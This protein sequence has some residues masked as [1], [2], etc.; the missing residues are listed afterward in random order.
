MPIRSMAD[1]DYIYQPWSEAKRRARSVDARR[2]LG[3]PDGMRR[4]YGVDVPDDIAPRVQEFTLIYRETYSA[5]ETAE[6]MQNIISDVRAERSEAGDLSL[7]ARRAR[8]EG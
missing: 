2:R 3:I 1:P 6:A 4:I 7:Q 5:A 8:G